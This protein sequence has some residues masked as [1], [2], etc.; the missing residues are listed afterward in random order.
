MYFN[1][2][3]FSVEMQA[4]LQ[5]SLIELT[6]KACVLLIMIVLKKPQIAQM[7]MPKIVQIERDII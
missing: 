4:S 6:Y 3:V 7:C 5:I 1:Q 2:C